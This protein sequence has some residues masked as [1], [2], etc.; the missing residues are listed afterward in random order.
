ML[1]FLPLKRT[2]WETL[3]SKSFFE[4]AGAGD[5][6]ARFL[7]VEIVCINFFF[8]EKEQNLLLFHSKAA[9]AG[10]HSQH[11]QAQCSFIIPACMD[12]F[13]NFAMKT[14]IDFTELD[15]LNHLPTLPES[16]LFHNISAGFMHNKKQ[17]FSP[18]YSSFVLISFP[19]NPHF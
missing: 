8:C 15:F 18:F 11:E 9:G 3:K 14:Q 17:K 6:C 19:Y 2:C 10:K 12:G 1:L 4:F 13:I 5:E 7:E 16:C